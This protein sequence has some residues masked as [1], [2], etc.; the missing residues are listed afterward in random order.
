MDFFLVFS[1]TH[2]QAKSGIRRHSVHVYKTVDFYLLLVRER[3]VLKIG[4]ARIGLV[5]GIELDKIWLVK[6]A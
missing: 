4:R 1:E 6:L 5:I 3:E 2:S